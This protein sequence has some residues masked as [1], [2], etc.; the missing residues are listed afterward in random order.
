MKLIT[1]KTDLKEIKLKSKGVNFN[2]KEAIFELDVLQQSL[3]QKY[4]REDR[5]FLRAYYTDYTSLFLQF[6]QE[7]AQ[8]NEPVHFSIMGGVRGGKSSSG[9][10]IGGMMSEARNKLYS[11]NKIM[12]SEYEFLQTLKD[13][14]FVEFGDCFVID[15]SKQAVYGV[16][17]TAKKVKIQDVQNIIAVNN[18]ST[19]WIKPDGWSFEGAM[20]GLRAFGRGQFDKFGKALPMR[21]NRFMLYNLQESSTGGSLP[22]GM[23]YIPHFADYLDNGKELWQQYS[24]KKQKWVNE[25]MSGTADA[26]MENMFKLAEKLTK[27]KHFSNLKKANEMEAFISTA[28]GSE[29]TR[30]EVKQLLTLC[31]LIRNGYTIDMIRGAV[32]NG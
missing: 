19:I 6:L 27:N 30:G 10:C 5:N 13:N 17:S 1:E 12:S 9:I 25:E 26:T 16:G 11:I 15:E 3:I 24:D 31:R 29:M 14:K 2:L 22:L 7:K 28:V 18:I 23:L 32:A 21:I 20:Y 4:L 8:L